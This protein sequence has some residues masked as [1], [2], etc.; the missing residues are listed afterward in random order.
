MSSGP[1]K[2]LIVAEKASPRS[3]L[4][5]TLES[6]GYDVGEAPNNETAL[7]CLRL[8]DYQAILLDF[9]VFG[10]GD[11][12]IC[13]QLRS[14]YPRLP[15]LVLS[16]CNLLDNKMEALEA[17]A[18]DYMI[19]PFSKREL[20]AR[21]RS[22]IR[23]FHAPAIGTSERLVVR[24]IVLDS[25]RHRVEKSGSEVSLTPTEFRTLKMLMQ[26]TGRPIAHSA[27][28]ATLWG[29][30]SKRHRENLRVVISALRSKLEDRPSHP[31][32]LITHKCFG[33]C[34]RDQ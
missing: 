21:L 14:L 24:E 23:R 30:E 3:R 2:V 22:A 33:Y 6:F 25:A 29:R 17:G 19:R 20:R 15:V 11:V 34:F 8:I 13:Y 26:Q 5:R 7:R 12:A 27:L 18:D 1:E 10:A 31:T 16:A 32:Y 9:P 28:L 4:R